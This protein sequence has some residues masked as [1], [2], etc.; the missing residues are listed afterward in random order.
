MKSKVDPCKARGEVKRKISV[1]AFTVQAV[2]ESLKQVA[3]GD[4][5]EN[6]YRICVVYHSERTMI[7]STDEFL[8]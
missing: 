4:S 3:Y 7:G 6:L 1:A 5:L 2:S 8:N